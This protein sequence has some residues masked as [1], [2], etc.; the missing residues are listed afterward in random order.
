VSKKRSERSVALR[1][2]PW[3][4]EGLRFECQADCGACC[5]NH[6]DYAYV[7][8]SGGEPE[9]LAEFLDLELD[10]FNARYTD[11]V[12]RHIVLK[13]DQPD[14]PFLSGSRC[15]VYPVRP[16]QCRSFPFW[17]ENLVA[18]ETWESVADFCPGVGRGPLLNLPVIEE[19]RKSRKP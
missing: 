16:V 17:D 8:L 14:C 2:R 1:P 7:Y 9:R 18:P 6:D 3:Y 10:E 15:S 19:Q 13:M 11:V 5:T 12:E 4:A